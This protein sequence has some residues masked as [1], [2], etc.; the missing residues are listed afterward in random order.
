V[1][2][3]VGIAGL[4]TAVVILAGQSNETIANIQNWLSHYLRINVSGTLANIVSPPLVPYSLASDI[5]FRSFW[6]IF[7]WRHIYIAAIWYW[8]PTVATIAAGVGLMVQTIK[9]VRSKPAADSG[10]D[11]S[12]LIRY[13]AFLF[14][15]VAVAWI[16]AILRS[17]ADQGMSAYQSHGRYIYIAVIPFAMLFAQGL[18]GLVKPAWQ[19]RALVIWII[20]LVAFDAL[21]FWGFL[22]PYYYQ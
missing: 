5:V 14:I 17:Q 2:L 15:V 13:L 19:R 18:L 16:M 10:G 6:A 21:C 11:Q 4:T 12:H 8:I 7:G 3:V 20:G 22:L 9:Y 1:S